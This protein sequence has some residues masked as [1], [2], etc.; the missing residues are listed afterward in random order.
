[1]SLFQLGVMFLILFL[2]LVMS[3]L[4]GYF[5]I[6]GVCTVPWIR[7]RRSICRRMLELGGFKSGESIL[8]LGS[9][10]GSI[11]LEA[12]AMGGEGIGIERLGLLVWY[13]RLRARI[14]SVQR[15]ATFIRGNILKDPIPQ[16]SLVTCYL[17]AEVNKKLEP[18]LQASLSEGTRVVSRDFTF[19]NLRK[20]ESRRFGRSTLYVYEI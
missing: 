1:M 15:K 8:D 14:C 2:L 7:T 11:V 12:V 10:D 20:I 4:V 3:I 9:G 19:P 18:R 13:A 17:F 6:Q 16:V 5:L